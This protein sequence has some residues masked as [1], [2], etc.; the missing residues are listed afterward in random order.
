[1]R[2]FYL[3]LM[4]ASCLHVLADIGYSTSITDVYFKGDSERT[5]S[6]TMT[7]YSDI[8]PEGGADAPY[9]LRLTLDHQARLSKTLVEQGADHAFNTPIYLALH[10]DNATGESFRLVAPPETVSIVRWVAGENA[11]WLQ[12]ASGAANWIEDVAG[13]PVPPGDELTARFM[14]ENPA[15]PAP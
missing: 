8:F 10:M 13:N 11:I 3:I 1:M 2:V 5:G 7:L 6:V 9:F 14:W 4:M 12:V 15:V